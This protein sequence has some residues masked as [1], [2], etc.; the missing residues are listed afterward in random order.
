MANLTAYGTGTPK[1]SDLLLGTKTATPNTNEQN[2][3]QNFTLSSVAAFSNSYSL[4][5]TVYTAQMD[6]AAG[7]EPVVVELQNTTGLKFVWTRLST[8]QYGATVAGTPFAANKF[9]GIIGAK[10]LQDVSVLRITDNTVRVDVA[11]TT[12][13]VAVDGLAAGYIE[14]RIYS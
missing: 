11:G 3:T 7:A 9:W 6:A 10:V 5:Y 8:G 14:I 13:G 1:A 2:I 12:T 4:G